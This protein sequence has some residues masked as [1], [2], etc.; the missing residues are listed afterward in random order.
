MC[1]GIV[2]KYQ[3]DFD[4]CFL[5]KVN[6][7]SLIGLGYIQILKLGIKLILL[8]FLDGKNVNVGGYKFG[9]GLEF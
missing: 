2:V 8:V 4:V 5:V 6:N 7:F 1:F 3:I 9:L